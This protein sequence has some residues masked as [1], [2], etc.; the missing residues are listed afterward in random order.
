MALLFVVDVSFY[1]IVAPM[2]LILRPSPRAPRP[3]P[4]ALRSSPRADVSR[5][6]GR[7]KVG[8]AERGVA[9]TELLFVVD[10]SFYHIVAPMALI[11][12][13]APCAL[14]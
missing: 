13:P 7:S 9:P 5:S 8:G 6:C 2:A 12:R 11:L 3:S 10:V 4:G 1:H 14:R